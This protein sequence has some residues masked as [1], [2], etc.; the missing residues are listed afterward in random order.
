MNTG[1]RA[2]QRTVESL[3]QHYF[4]GAA[5]P[6]IIGTGDKLFASVYLDPQNPPKAIMLQWNDGSW[7]HRAYWGTAQI[8]FGDHNTPGQRHRGAL[9]EPGQWVRLEVPAD[10]VGLNA[11][12]KVH[13][14]AFTQFGGTVTWDTAGLT[15]RTPQGGQTFKS[16]RLWELATAEGKGLPKPVQD[17]IKV[18]VSERTD[19]QRE[20]LRRYFLENIYVEA[21]DVLQPLAQKRTALETALTALN[22]EIPKTMVA[23]EMAQPRQAFLLNRGEYDNRGEPVD[24]IVPAAL[25]PLP[26]DAPRNRLGLAEWLIDSSHP[27]MSRVTVNRWWQRYFGTGLVKTSEDFGIQGETP[28]HPELLD[29]LA[30][31]FMES[32]WDVKQLQKLIV[33]SATYRQ[34]AAKGDDLLRDPAI[35]GSLAARD[36]ACRPR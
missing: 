12:A 19:E 14:W 3:G 4:T 21:Q 33:M 35:A 8:P 32:G 20:T 36:F 6:L 31:E 30:V 2:S 17:A 22:E 13:G 9:P 27:L 7:E 29:W 5:Q 23:E 1:A 15:T 18:A 28:S 24:R 11:G 25:P 16:Q 10:L 26:N 34:S